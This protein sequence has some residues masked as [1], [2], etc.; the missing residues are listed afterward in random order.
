MPL[1]PVASE[2]EGL[3]VYDR[4]KVEKDGTSYFL[5]R[6]EGSES[7]LLG[8][9]GDTGDLEGA[10]PGPAGID[11]LPLTP[12]NA[13][14]LRQRLPWL[15]PKP[16]GLMT[17]AGFGDRLGMA[18]PGHVRA[19]RQ[20]ANAGERIGPIFAQQSVRE[21]TRTG[22]SPQQ[23]VDDATWGVMQEGW[24]SPWGADADHLK[25]QR[26]T[27]DFV[28]AGYTFFTIDPGDWVD[29]GAESIPQIEL[30]DKLQ[31]LPW[32]T[33][34][35]SLSDLEMRYLGRSYSVEGRA[36]LF[37]REILWRAVAKYG[38]AVNHTVA[39]Y[40]HLL[41]AMGD[42]TFDLEVSVDETSTTTS[43][44]EHFY[45]A[46]ELRR[47]GV[48]WV[49]LAPR[50]VGSF[51]KGVDYVGD[52]DTFAEEFAHHAALARELGPYKISLHSGSDKFSIYRI[53]ADLTDRG[54]DSPQGPLL[55]LKTAGTSYL[56][57][58]RTIAEVDSDLFREILTY[59]R[60][61]YEVDRATY[62]VSAQLEKVPASADVK[63]ADLPGLL[64]VFDARQVLHVTF[65]SALERFGPQL[66]SAMGENEDA[67]YGHLQ[68]HFVRHLVPF[69][70]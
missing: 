67:H 1:N 39:M 48:Q 31:G 6:P 64:D 19:L 47:L 4:S 17:S 65:G 52:L 35:D 60:E 3:L 5:A 25:T 53:A 20:L 42:R 43:V 55:H 51:E 70:G 66:K 13:V 49:S 41:G 14:V 18:T 56:E 40:R 45:I 34:E 29:D 30:E 33:L 10:K 11:L 32:N 59:A 28:D 61:C 63:E 69:A 9:R 37:D 58:L 27:R 2:M 68:S 8:V 62:H 50:F 36:E 12:G 7:K 54:S 23:V 24:S 15:A 21:N 22:R 46:S 26:V 16:L 38:A 44:A 57:A